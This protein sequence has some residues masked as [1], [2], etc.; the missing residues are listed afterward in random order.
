MLLPEG[1]VLFGCAVLGK[2]E[3]NMFAYK[4]DKPVEDFDGFNGKAM[5]NSQLLPNHYIVNEQS[6]DRNVYFEN[7]KIYDKNRKLISGF[8]VDLI[9]HECIFGTN[10]PRYYT[11][12]FDYS[13]INNNILLIRNDVKHEKAVSDLE[14][15]D[16]HVTEYDIEGNIVWD[17]C[18]AEH[19]DQLGL[20]EKRRK[21]M[22]KQSVDNLAFGQGNDWIHLNT[23]VA[24]GENKWYDHGDERFHPEN[25]MIC[26][27]SLSAVY[28]ID[29][30]TK[31]IVYTLKGRDF[32]FRLQHYAHII[33]KGLPGEGNILLLNNHSDSDPSVLEINPIT[34]EVVCKI[35]GRFTSKAMGSVQKLEDGSYL[36][37]C[38]NSMNVHRYGADGKL[39]EEIMLQRPFY[40]VN[41]YPA[42]WLK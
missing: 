42:E 37:G 39:I 21:A 35:T 38:S 27:R 18:A 41:A 12:A 4:D 26:S 1:Y 31:D 2:D 10:A 23:A 6:N 17:W 32:R 11:P 28:I 40:R 24:L 13:K 29:K 19:I 8:E 22:K 9:N 30:K 7:V 34:M 5:C 36:I 16:N 14:I 33:P 3:A 15:I 25:I 20:N